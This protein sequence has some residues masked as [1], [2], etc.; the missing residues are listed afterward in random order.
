MIHVI[1]KRLMPALMTLITVSLFL[2][3]IGTAHL[4]SPLTVSI[5]SEALVEG[6]NLYIEGM[7]SEN[8]VAIW[9]F[10]V[11]F[12]HRDIVNVSFYNTYSYAVATGELGPGHYI[13]I[14]QHPGKNGIFDVDI[15]MGDAVYVRQLD[16]VR[17][18]RINGTSCLRGRVAANA[19]EQVITS[20]PSDDICSLIDFDIEEPFIR[21]Q[22]VPNHFLSDKVTVTASTNLH[23][24]TG[25]FVTACPWPWD[26]EVE[27]RDDRKYC[28]EG[29]ARVTEGE[30]GINT[31]SFEVNTTEFLETPYRITMQ[32]T[33][34]SVNASAQLNLLKL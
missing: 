25:I 4:A 24:G 8:H 33:E 23:P 30:G 6:E 3:E 10:G 11:N 31:I 14:V 13:A 15:D 22:P 1:P 27:G 20:Q 32:S 9:I 2:T 28:R 7:A 21:I 18:F 12:W 29:T 34:A 19:L 17:V 16:G 26:R 5:S